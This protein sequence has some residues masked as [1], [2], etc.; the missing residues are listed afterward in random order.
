MP[1]EVQITGQL[2]DLKLSGNPALD[3]Q[4]AIK[5]LQGNPTLQSLEIGPVDREKLDLAPLSIR[6]LTVYGGSQQKLGP[7][8][9]I[10]GKPETPE[11]DLG[12]LP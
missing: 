2:M 5:T 3:L 8:F 7:A 1:P 4:S 12:S 10:D 9:K 6:S 11:S